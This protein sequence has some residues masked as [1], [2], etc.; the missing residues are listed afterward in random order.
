[1]IRTWV[2][3]DLSGNVNTVSQTIHIA[4][5]SPWNLQNDQIVWP[6]D[7]SVSGCDAALAPD[8]LPAPY[9]MPVFLSVGACQSVSSS[10]EDEILWVSEPACY[11]VYRTWTV[12]DFCQWTANSGTDEG[13]WT[14]VQLLTVTDDEAPE[15]VNPPLDFEVPLSGALSCSAT[16][17]LPTPV[18]SDCSDHLIL[19]AQGDLGSGFSFSNVAPGDYQMKYTASDGC[20]NTSEHIFTVRVADQTAPTALCAGNITAELAPNHL[21]TLTAASFNLASFDNC[22]AADD[23]RFSFSPDPGDATRVFSCDEPGAQSID[24]FVTDEAGNQ[25]VCSVLVQISDGGNF[26][27]ADAVKISGRLHL[28][29]GAGIAHAN[30][31]ADGSGLTPAASDMSGEYVISGDLSG[32]SIS[33]RP[34]KN[35]DPLNGVTTFDLAKINDHILGKNYLDTPYKRIAAD[36]NNSGQITVSDLILIQRVIL[37]LEPAFTNN[38]SWRFVPADYVFPDPDNPFSPPFPESIQLTNIAGDQNNLDF[39]G[40]KIGDVT[41]NANPANA[42]APTT[43]NRTNQI[44]PLTTPDQTALPGETVAVPVFATE[45]SGCAGWQ[46]TFEF[47]PEIWDFLSVET[48]TFSAPKFGTTFAAEGSITALWYQTDVA[49][50]AD[51]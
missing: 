27:G 38:T 16:V 3:T 14:Y 11:F 21:A 47:D 51:E 34:E 25:S 13:L 1:L 24:L 30:V 17:Q 7:Y 19:T 45:L 20:G 36:A 12:I 41:G 5:A 6:A 50:P 40:I 42:D 10:W 4:N 8:E 35:T 15:F 23:L 22:T 2:A 39:I 9:G 31:R 26:C 44:F 43:E 29:T 28:P 33:V 46:A 37:H 32:Q 49:P 48:G 18:V